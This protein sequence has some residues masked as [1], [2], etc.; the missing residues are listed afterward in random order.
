MHTIDYMWGMDFGFHDANPV[1]VFI[2]P[3][4]KHGANLST[5]R[6]FNTSEILLIILILNEIR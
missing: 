4:Q 5:F 6:Y 2:Y 1:T 3:H